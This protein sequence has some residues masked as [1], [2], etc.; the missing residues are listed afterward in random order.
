MM[1]SEIFF[2]MAKLN[3]KENY[4]GAIQNPNNC[5]MYKTCVLD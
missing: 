4:L 2:R 5:T 3:I 1:E